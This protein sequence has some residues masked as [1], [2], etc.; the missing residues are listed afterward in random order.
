MLIK[1]GKFSIVLPGCCER[2]TQA[3]MPFINLNYGYEDRGEPETIDKAKPEWR[4]PS[5]GYEWIAKLTGDIV[6]Y[7]NSDLSIKF[8]P[9]CGQKLPEIIRVE[10]PELKIHL[11][12]DGGYYCRTCEERNMNCECY[13]EVV[14]FDALDYPVGKE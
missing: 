10:R 14:L 3:K 5:M 2:S 9:F 13:P 6:A 4:C 12:E 7:Y 1:K 11:D 8:C